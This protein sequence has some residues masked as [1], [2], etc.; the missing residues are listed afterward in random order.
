MTWPAS[1]SINTP[2]CRSACCCADRFPSATLLRNYHG[3][4]A[5]VV[6]GRDTVVPEQFGLRLYEGYAGPKW[7]WRFPNGVHTQIMAPPEV[8]WSEVVAFWQNP[9]APH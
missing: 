5:V 3:P 4:V 2:C 8:F 1:A 7:L 6:D 9:G